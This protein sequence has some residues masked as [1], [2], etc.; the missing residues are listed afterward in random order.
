MR[1]ALD[2]F[3]AGI[4]RHHP[5]DD[6]QQGVDDVFDPYDRYS[7]GAYLL[8]GLDQVEHLA[9]GQTTGDLIEQQQG[10][11]GGERPGELEAL[12]IQ[13]RQRAGEQ[14]GLV[15]HAGLFE[16]GHRGVLFRCRQPAAATER[17]ADEHVL[18]HGQPF[19]RARD[20]RGASDAAV[21]PHVSRQV[22]DVLTGQRDRAAVGP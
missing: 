16:S 15:E 12:A 17:A 7:A 22:G 20:L 10:G 19:E 18:E 4:D 21:A 5:V 9:L 1:I 14:V 11:L 3:A 8:D 2:Q 6:A 13:Q